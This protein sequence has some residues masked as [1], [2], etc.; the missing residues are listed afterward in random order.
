MTR[1]DDLEEL[2]M[3]L[4]SEDMHWEFSKESLE[5]TRDGVRVIIIWRGEQVHVALY[6]IRQGM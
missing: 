5:E 4:P 1:T 6:I 3:Q 2:G